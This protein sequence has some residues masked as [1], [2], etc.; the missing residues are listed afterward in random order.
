MDQE[1][2]SNGSAYAD[3]DQ[4]GDLDLIVSNIL[5]P[6]FIYRN[7]ISGNHWLQ[8]ELEY[9]PGNPDGFGTEV[10]V[11][12]SGQLQY[13]MMN[14]VKGFFSCSEPL[15]HFGLGQATNVDSIVL[16]WP[17]GKQEVQR[18][19]QVDQRM[20]WKPGD[21]DSYK[22]SELKFPTLFS[23]LDAFSDFS[24]REDVFIDFKREKL[25]P[26]MLS[27]EGPCMSAGDV[28]GDGHADLYLGNGKGHRKL[29]FLQGAN[30]TFTLS[31]QQVFAADSVFEDCGS[32]LEDLDGDGDRDLV[33]ISGGNDKKPNDI[34]YRVRYYENAGQGQFTYSNRL[35]DIRVNAG[36]ILAVDYDRDKDLDLIIG[37]ASVPGSFPD[38]PRSFLLRND[39][40]KYRDVTQEVFPELERLGMI[41][42]IRAGDLNRDQRV[43]VV[44]A[45]KWMPVR[46]FSFMGQYFEEKTMEFGLDKTSGWWNAIYLGDI[47]QDGDDDLI[48]GNVGL[49]HRFITS[50]QYPVTL[51]ARDFDQNG[52][53]DPI[54]CYHHDGQLYPFAGRDAI[55]GQIPALKKKF[56][57]YETY[58][59]ATLEDIFSKKD[60]KESQVL[61]V[62]TFQ[63]TYWR[64][65]GGIMTMVAL[66]YQ[67]QLAPVFDI[68]VEDFNGDDRKDI[69][70]VGNFLYAETE[71][72]EMDAGNGTLLLQQEDGSFRFILNREHGFW[73]QREAREIEMITLSD[74]RRAIVTGNNQ[75]P[76]E[77]YVLTNSIL[78]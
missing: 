14:T 37:G 42:D 19:V 29:L 10:W 1:T 25:L 69:L 58:A 66:P 50:E 48:G 22:K 52:F 67:S 64:N 6:A 44:F 51:V 17:N 76:V 36:S 18:Q 31:D 15:L 41:T 12:T 74:G 2:F 5:D 20:K 78:R 30:K 56:V 63:T 72:G 53:I 73:A 57:R 21:G 27:A 32:V 43:E 24:H 7:D 47:D 62:N 38:I 54:M 61:T 71:T 55:I 45:G 28:D 59:T 75:G 70:M 9:R 46:I 34:T 77:V 4:D 60:L 16:R 3:L 49:N 23:R 68:L 33:V 13:Q 40:G 39:R 65:D 11:Y 35:P 8:L 26:Y